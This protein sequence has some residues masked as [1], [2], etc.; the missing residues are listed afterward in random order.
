MSSYKKL[1][2]ARNKTALFMKSVFIGED[3]GHKEI[4]N[5]VIHGKGEKVIF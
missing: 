4:F 2:L 5:E 1:Y 3:T